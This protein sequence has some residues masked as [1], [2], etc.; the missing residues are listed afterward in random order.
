[1]DDD[2]TFAADVEAAL[3]G[4][5]EAVPY[6]EDF[7][8]EPLPELK[9][10]G[11]RATG[12]RLI[13]K[14][15]SAIPLRAPEWLIDGEIPLGGL[16]LLAGRE[17]TG[18]STY[19]ADLAARVTTGRLSLAR[20]RAHAVSVIATEDSYESVIRPRLQAAGANLDKVFTVE[21]EDAEI[22]DLTVSLPDDIQELERLVVENDIALIILDPLIS[23][24]RVG[25]DTHKDAE[26]RQALE[27][28]TA[29]AERTRATVLGLIHIAKMQTD[30]PLTSIMGSRA[31]PAVARSVLYVLEAP[32]SWEGERGKRFIGVGKSNYGESNTRMRCYRIQGEY[33]GS[34]SNGHPVNASRVVWLGRV[35]GVGVRD[36]L[37][38]INA[39][40]PKEDVMSSFREDLERVDH[41]QPR[42]AR[43]NSAPAIPA[44]LLVPT[45]APDP[46]VEEVGTPEL[47]M[48]S[49]GGP[50]RAEAVAVF[51]APVD[52][53]V[54]DLDY[55]KA[56]W[57]RLSQVQLFEAFNAAQLNSCLVTVGGKMIVSGAKIL[58]A[59]ADQVNVV[60]NMF[61]GFTS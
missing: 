56:H 17:G 9:R 40:G 1:V 12:R 58:A 53:P 35:M 11:P 16:T 43:A 49:E 14:P 37:Q 32:G 55:I 33:V 20:G 48:I 30:D 8:P 24:L 18:K 5:G 51:G 3:R 47:D 34:D 31:F 59:P 39:K 36:M 19:W 21:P 29:L 41:P 54:S 22:G 60:R 52:Q 23:R 50:T 57:K 25:L 10:Y 46:V 26:V 13:A 27:P 15:I 6:P 45:A 44:T 28:L 42:A 2:E 7:E 4:E 61:E 38:C